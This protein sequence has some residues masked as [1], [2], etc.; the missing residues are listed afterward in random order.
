MATATKGWSYSAG[1]RGK[2]RVRAFA[3]PDGRLFLEFYED[4]KRKRVALGHR[5][6][7]KAEAQ[8]DETAAGLRK[9]E[10]PKAASVTLHQLFDSYGREVT[11]SKAPET[12]RHD[13]VCADMFCR[14]FGRN[15]KPE[16]LSRT[17]WDRFIRARRE[18]RIGPAGKEPRPVGPRAVTRDLK[19]LRAVLKWATEARDSQGRFYLDRDPLKGL[20][21]PREANPERPTVTDGQYKALLTTAENMNPTFRL[22]LIMVHETGH[23]I[24]A[25]RQLRWSDVQ[26][27]EEQV[28][29]PAE[30]DKQGRKHTTPLSPEAV[31]ALRGAQR[32]TG[33]IGQAWVFPAPRDASKPCSHYA[34][35]QWLQRAVKYSGLKVPK[36]FGWHSFR[37]KLATDMKDLPLRDL[38]HLGGWKDPGTV[39]KCYQQPEEDRI[40]K[41]L[42]SR[43]KVG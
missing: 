20:P 26:L 42:A 37:R 15:T 30:T 43:R 25:V 21:F 23:R 8:A 35:S 16:T 1:K 18:G 24:G 34:V 40:R 13:R 4:G 14:F 17:D 22:L 27:D 19:L 5:D 11:P 9:Q 38:C 7:D 31:E 6:T 39:L 3:K 33:A 41:A 10:P 12:Q 2:N 28:T 32:R 36:R 29:W